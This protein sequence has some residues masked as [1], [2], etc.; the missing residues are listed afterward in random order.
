MQLTIKS[1]LIYTITFL[2]VLLLAIGGLGIYHLGQLNQSL[3]TVYEDRV[4][5]LKQ[6]KHIADL[7]AVNVI[8][9]ANKANAGLLDAPT[10]LKALAEAQ[11]QISEEW[12]SY[13]STT[14]TSD[15]KKLST[16]AI[17]LFDK[18]NADIDRLEQFLQQHVGPLA[19]ELGD[20]D[21]PLYQTIDPIGGKINELIVLQLDVA[22][23]E[24]LG[25]QQ[26][27]EQV[28]LL[29]LILLA[30]GIG[31]AMLSGY[32]LIRAISTPL[33][34]A[35]AVAQGIAKGE[36]DHQ[37]VVHSRDETGQ[38][39][40]A[41]QQMQQSIQSF[42][43]A[44]QHMAAQHAAGTMSARMDAAQ[45]PGTFGTMAQEVNTLVSE[46]IQVIQQ[47]IA[48]IGEYSQG[49]FSRDMPALPGEKAQ[50]T[51]AIT[52][53]KRALLAISGDIQRLAE[54]GAKGDF[55]QRCNA[56]Q[57]QYMFR[58]MLENLNQLII[59]CDV[60]FNDIL[61]VSEALGRGD[62][63][64]TI[65]QD[66]PGLFG[67]AQQGVNGT[68]TTLR[69]L[70]GEVNEL[71]SA[72]ANQG[73]FSQRLELANKQGFSLELAEQLNQLSSVTDNGLR[74]VMRV[75]SALAKGD[76]TQMITHSYPGLFGETSTAVNTTVSNLQQLVGEIQLSGLTIQRAVGEI[77]QGNTDLS[78]RTE[79][80]AAN[81]EETAASTE[82]LTGT[83]RQNA[84]HA[85]EAN[86]LARES[87]RIAKEGGQSVRQVVDTMQ[88]IQDAS[89]KIV[90]IIGVIDG[91]AFQTNILALNAAVEAAR[92]GE[93]G[94]GFAVVAS[95]VRNLAQR[96][97]VAAK[98]I[99]E[100]ISNSVHQ[101]EHGSQQVQQAGHTMGQVEASIDRVST[102]IGEIAAASSE[103]SAGIAQVNQ[104]VTQMDE[105]TQQ[106]AALVEEAA[107]AAES[108][109]EQAHVL[110]EAVGTFKLKADTLLSKNPAPLAALP[111]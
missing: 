22:K 51:A 74:D 110:A 75:S 56:E 61:R 88:A 9:T 8:D 90:D 18:A 30:V 52:E 35:V 58:S 37:I 78:R 54:A 83:V 73:D 82:E 89:R 26:T 31:L 21:G 17:G 79:T 69:S 96:S 14:L 94:R 55:S 62:L 25:A 46:H 29:S 32:L 27:Y 48:V 100:L 109:A 72:A 76:L 92:A 104:A 45:Y 105:V 106:N 44:Q 1:R 91:I 81:L 3:K 39:M 7:Y 71:V 15:E 97:A 47:T 49:N 103:Q 85:K 60:G 28:R 93:Q 70:I 42:V 98:E 4:V 57:Y 34:R 86:N 59:T 11:Q 16:E 66:Y 12:K 111:A 24:Y 63:S 68:V 50:I 6:L 33:S 101:V 64:Q 77:V 84:D 40:L 19:G 2:A 10:A 5:P 108:L 102:L 41:M 13:Q 67:R 20:F 23:A 65:T 43:K 95:E 87:V 36:L 107:A 38:L 53:V 99:K 80:Q